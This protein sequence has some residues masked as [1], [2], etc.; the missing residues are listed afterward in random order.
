MNH[1]VGLSEAN[2]VARQTEKNTRRRG[3]GRTLPNDT[4]LGIVDALTY[5][6]GVWLILTPFVL[7][8]LNGESSFHGGWNAVLIG[9]A[10]AAT[11]AVSLVDPP[12]APVTNL[13]RLPLGGW[14]AVS[15][16]LLDD[17]G[18]APAIAWVANNAVTG[19]LVL[20]LW[21]VGLLLVTRAGTGGPSGSGRRKTGR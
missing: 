15:P 1:R 12:T 10:L 9:I 21:G 11:G 8:P 19:L 2:T 20:V 3:D 6:I 7:Q 18:G 17:E 5:L 14:L 4:G 13:M 16:F